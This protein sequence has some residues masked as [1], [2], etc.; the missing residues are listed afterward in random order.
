M[1]TSRAGDPDTQRIWL[2]INGNY[3]R[4]GG[5]VN[6]DP[7]GAPVL[8]EYL[9]G[10][11]VLVLRLVRDARRTRLQTAMQIRKSSWHAHLPRE[12]LGIPTQFRIDAAA[13]RRCL[14][15]EGDTC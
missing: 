13:S 8:V 9:A 3:C 14:R 12:R 10:W 15:S 4:V 11:P 6:W 7:A 2:G 1:S 5:K